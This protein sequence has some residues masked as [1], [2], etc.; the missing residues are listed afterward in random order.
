MQPLFSFERQIKSFCFP[1][2]LI[3]VFVKPMFTISALRYNCTRIWTIVGYK[4]YATGIL[5]ADLPTCCYPISICIID[6]IFVAWTCGKSAWKYK[7]L[8]FR[9]SRRWM[10]LV[11]SQ[12]IYTVVV[13]VHIAITVW[14]YLY[15]L[16]HV[17]C[18]C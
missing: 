15:Y 4:T 8:F 17:F 7:H 3:L 13:V 9:C 10:R 5:F 16:W 12:R 2:H 18:F 1:I 11:T 14:V 6:I